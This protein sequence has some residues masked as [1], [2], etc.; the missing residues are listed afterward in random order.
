MLQVDTK[1]RGCETMTRDGVKNR[2]FTRLPKKGCILLVSCMVF[3]FYFIVV[4]WIVTGFVLNP[5]SVNLL[6]FTFY[7]TYRTFGNRL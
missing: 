2:R 7:D 5:D 6:L 1:T 3:N 4:K